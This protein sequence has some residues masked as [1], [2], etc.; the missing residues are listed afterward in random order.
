MIAPTSLEAYNQIKDTLPEK[1]KAVLVALEKM[2][3]ACNDTLA[4]RM[5]WPINCVTP[6][7]GELRKLGLIVNTEKRIHNGFNVQYFKAAK[8][9]TLF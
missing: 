7:T 6:R 5:T 2:D 1:R 8:P 4:W 3:E 9:E